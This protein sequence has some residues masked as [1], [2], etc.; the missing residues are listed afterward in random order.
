[1][2]LPIK[3]LLKT[4]ITFCSYSS[5]NTIVYDSGCIIEPLIIDSEELKQ[6][7]AVIWHITILVNGEYYYARYT[8]E[9]DNPPFVIL[10]NE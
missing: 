4:Q 2:K 9:K 6:Y 8:V 10:E 3:I 7:N 5:W 1:M